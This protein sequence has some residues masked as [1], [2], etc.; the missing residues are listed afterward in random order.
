MFCGASDRAQLGGMVPIV[1]NESRG[2]VV[3]YEAE[4]YVD[5]GI[6]V[7]NGFNLMPWDEVFP[8]PD[9][10]PDQEGA[11]EDKTENEADS[12]NGRVVKR[13]KPTKHEKREQRL[14]KKANAARNRQL[15][16]QQELIT[17]AGGIPLPTRSQFN[18]YGSRT[19]I[20]EIY[21]K[22]IELHK[23]TTED[24]KKPLDKLF[25]YNSIAMYL[26][27][28]ELFLPGE[29][30]NDNNILFAYELLTYSFLKD[31]LPALKQ[32]ALLYPSLVQLF[33]HYPNTEDLVSLLPPELK[34][35]RFVFLPINF[36][37]DYDTIDLEEINVGDHWALTVLDVLSGELKVYDS[38]VAESDECNSK[39][40]KELTTRLLKCQSLFGNQMNHIQIKYMKCDQQTNFDDCGIYVSMITSMLIYRLKMTLES[41]TIS[42]DLGRARFEPLSGRYIMLELVYKVMQSLS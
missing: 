10:E 7:T 30:L 40:L 16:R 12:E 36:I 23:S 8:E 29:W 32:I 35:A 38:M 1:R 13:K 15:K 11:D 17:A 3:D 26:G 4:P 42:L 31:D 18:P 25:Q 21:A 9:L 24:N 14:Q 2:Y 37:D 34:Q 39:L 5:E 41:Q 27:D 6:I 19:K 20:K 22:I 28:L 33:L